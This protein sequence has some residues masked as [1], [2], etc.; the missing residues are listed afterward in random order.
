LSFH[1]GIDDLVD[2]ASASNLNVAIKD[3]TAP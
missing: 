2:A 3:L 1:V